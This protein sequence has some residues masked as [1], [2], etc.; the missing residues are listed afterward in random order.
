M[1]SCLASVW[2]N[3]YTEIVN[4]PH[5]WI[6]AVACLAGLLLLGAR[7]V[8]DGGPAS[9]TSRSEIT[10]VR[11]VQGNLVVMVKVPA[12]RRRVTLETRAQVHRGAW[13]PRRVEVLDSA[14]TGE[15][16]FSIPLGSG[17]ETVRVREETEE[18]LGLPLGF[19]IGTNTFA[20]Q[21]QSTSV[22]VTGSAPGVLTPGTTPTD[23]KSGQV[24]AGAGNFSAGTSASVVESDIWKLEGHTL[25][26]FNQQRGL[27]VIDVTD[28]DHPVLTGTLPLAVYGE[29]L[30]RLPASRAAADGSTWLALLAQQD[31]NGLASQ[32]LLVQVKEGRPVLQGSLPASGQIRESRLVG[33]TLLIAGADWFS[34]PPVDIK[35][36]NGVVIGS[37]VSAW[38]ART[39]ISTF[40]LSNPA[41][42]IVQTPVTLAASPNAILATDQFLFV[43]TTGTRQPS[44]TE[45]PAA[46]AVAGNHAL[47]A[48]DIS[49]PG[50]QPVQSGYV[51]TAGWVSDKF[52]IG[53]DGATLAA[54]SQTDSGSYVEAS[55]GKGGTTNLVW[56]WTAPKTVLETFSFATPTAPVS[57]GQLTLVTN[58]S[59]YAARFSNSRV[60]VVTYRQV[61]PLWIVDLSKP[62]APVVSGHLS[63]PGYSTFLQPMADDTRLLALGSDGSR[64]RLQLFDVANPAKPQ[65]LSEATLGTGWSWSE[66]NAN[67]KAFTVFPEAGLALLPW[68]GQR[69]E[70]GNPVWF[71]GT[72]MIDLDL[73]AGTVKARGTLESLSQARRASLVGNRVLAISS[74]ELTTVDPANR[75]LP[76]VVNRLPLTTEVDRVLLAGNSLLLID[77]TTQPNPR[78]RMTAAGVP[79]STAA[80]L[81]LDPIPV[82]GAALHGEVLHLFQSSADTWKSVTRQVT[83]EQVTITKLPPIATMVT[84][85]VTQRVSP[86]KVTLVS[87]DVFIREESVTGLGTV[88]LTTNELAAVITLPQPQA[89]NWITTNWTVEFPPIPGETGVRTLTT[90]W[91]HPE[92]VPLPDVVTEVAVVESVLVPQPPL[93]FTNVVTSLVYDSIPV[94]GRSQ[95]ATVRVGAGSLTALGTLAIPRG[96][97]DNGYYAPPM[98]ALWVAP[99]VVVWTERSDGGYGYGGPIFT[100]AAGLKMQSVADTRMVGGLMPYYYSQPAHFHAVDVSQPVKPTLLSQTVIGN[101]SATAGQFWSGSSGS[102]LAD[103]KVFLSHQT[104]FSTPPVETLTLVT[105][106]DGTVEKH[107]LYQPGVYEA[108]HFLDVV[109]FADPA[110]PTLRD[111]LPLPG[112]L[113]GV[114]HAGQLVYTRGPLPGEAKDPTQYLQVG[115][116][117]GTAVSLVAS[118]PLPDGWPSV[119]WIA[120][121]GRVWLGRPATTSTNVSS[122]ETW[123]LGAS[124]KF[125]LRGSVAVPEAV[126]DLLLLDGLLM[127]G[128]AT[129]V[130]LLDPAASPGSQPVLSQPKPCALWYDAANAAA[131]RTDGLWIP[132]GS[133]GLWQIAP[134][135]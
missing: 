27:Q 70:N 39:T 116:Y 88:S 112:S 86:R 7:L 65:L 55:P 48:F 120:A 107:S 122:L 16:R 71:Q 53:F 54:V 50:H 67:E 44:P 13:T 100:L 1:T 3:S 37:Q 18:E 119:Q 8:A 118:L 125:E 90:T 35:D 121:D 97:N 52:R 15:V 51:M 135:R 60:Y 134:A 63:I 40:D 2:S 20:P 59:V 96:T 22:G 126:S 105:N 11:A 69:F 56:Q 130:L 95:V 24:A 47:V 61:D 23:A 117:D 34:P 32:V 6:R 26:F 104:T 92:Y 85:W 103:G 81:D 98:K 14:L 123:A 94:P 33:E 76:R 89:T 101:T 99:Q 111:P 113:A 79:E 133:S 131:S 129:H 127:A 106:L 21:L 38:E 9:S 77:G 110:V 41:L 108:R 114:S 83:N 36:T 93:R 84:N 115:A 45:R 57:L 87:T 80:V 91:I 102:F 73:A 43:A 30:Y 46:W 109:D 19:F 5:R 17:T 132:R 82:T 62:T 75:D 72:Q 42:P 4:L 66:A 10:L 74:T 58:E 31:C 68:Q 64:T 49:Q 124:E 128:S 12:G 29:D 78:V 25:Y 28:A